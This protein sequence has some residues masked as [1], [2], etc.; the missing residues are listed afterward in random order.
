MGFLWSA[1]KSEIGNFSLAITLELLIWR[2]AWSVTVVER[3][4]VIPSQ[5]LIIFTAYNLT[6]RDSAGTKPTHNKP[7]I[8]QVENR[9][10]LSDSSHHLVSSPRTKQ[11]VQAVPPARRETGHWTT[12]GESA[13]DQAEGQLI[14]GAERDRNRLTYHCD[15]LTLSQSWQSW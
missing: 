14:W 12:G 8:M 6:G 3:S 10:L 2:V 4:P 13:G 9:K 1:K 15:T 7:D 11:P 5:Q